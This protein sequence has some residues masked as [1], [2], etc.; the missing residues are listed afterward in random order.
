MPPRR[1]YLITA[2]EGGGH[3]GTSRD[4]SATRHPGAGSFGQEA[5]GVA[6]GGVELAEQFVD[7]PLDGVDLALEGDDSLMMRHHDRR[8]PNAPITGVI[9]RYR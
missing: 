2:R 7:I 4:Y 8:A 5:L 1:N 3:A 9:C 6:D